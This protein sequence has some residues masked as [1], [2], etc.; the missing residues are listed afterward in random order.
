MRD[1]LDA[2]WEKRKIM[3]AG[4][5]DAVCNYGTTPA[6]PTSRGGGIT[7]FAEPGNIY[8][9]NAVFQLLG[10]VDMHWPGDGSCVILN[11]LVFLKEKQHERKRIHGIADSGNR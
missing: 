2:A 3:R 10:P 1:E 11:I 9:A 4:L 6:H 8:W 5:Q 7:S